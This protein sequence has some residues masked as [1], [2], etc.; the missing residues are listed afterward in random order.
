MLSIAL[1]F[2]LGGSLEIF[3]TVDINALQQ[4]RMSL[5]EKARQGDNT[6]D[7]SSS[8]KRPPQFVTMIDVLSNEL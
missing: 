5:L 8:T 6:L 4:E 3:P 7:S 1:D 2:I